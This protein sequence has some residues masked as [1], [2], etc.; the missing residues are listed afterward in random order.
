MFSI[1]LR[2]TLCSDRGRRG[3]VT[4]GQW[5]SDCVQPRAGDYSVFRIFI[6]RKET[7]CLDWER[8]YNLCW[9]YNL[10]SLKSWEEETLL[11]EKQ[12]SVN[13]TLGSN[14]HG[15]EIEPTQYKSFEMQ[16]CKSFQV[17]LKL[18]R[19]PVL[20]SRLCLGWYFKACAS[21][22]SPLTPGVTR[23]LL[24]SLNMSRVSS[25]EIAG[26]CG[27]LC[28]VEELL[29]DLLDKLLCCSLSS[30]S[31]FALSA[32]FSFHRGLKTFHLVSKEHAIF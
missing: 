18:F 13:W 28:E 23:H 3:L 32:I 17:S 5:L 26:P 2:C 25:V 4:S 24:M 7:L 20:T 6:W 21:P 11:K 8:R 30:S 31:F 10:V 12:C 1:Y 15:N 9:D 19:F 14:I 16:S 29:K 22:L 27:P